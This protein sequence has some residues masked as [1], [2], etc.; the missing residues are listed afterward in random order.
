M[1]TLHMSYAYLLSLTVSDQPLKTN[2]YIKVYIQNNV[3]PIFIII[4]ILVTRHL[5]VN[6]QK[7]FTLSMC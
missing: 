4:Y 6:N 5:R 2:E 1:L 7:H 3:A